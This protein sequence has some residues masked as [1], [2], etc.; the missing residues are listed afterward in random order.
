LTG[1]QITSYNGSAFS[2]QGGGNPQVP[3]IGSGSVTISKPSTAVVISGK[4][5]S[6]DITAA[7]AYAYSQSTAYT[8]SWSVNSQVVGSTAQATGSNILYIVT[9]S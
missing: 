6:N 9:G 4:D 5:Y 3:V 2:A 8:N 7:S 1:G